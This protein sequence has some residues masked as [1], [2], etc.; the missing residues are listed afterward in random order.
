MGTPT[1]D[2][3]PTS[4]CARCFGSGRI[5]GEVQPKYINVKFSG[6]RPGLDFA[7]PASIPNGSFRLQHAFSCLYRLFVPNSFNI[8]LDWAAT[9]T[10][11]TVGQPFFEDV[12]WNSLPAD[13]CQTH[14]GIDSSPSI[15]GTFFGGEID[16]TW[17][18]DGL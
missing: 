16:I 15:V 13:L 9:R 12:T 8:R 5:L 14:L 6:V 11:V 18:T 17:S 7:P 4:G 1:P 3:E 10:R 2:N